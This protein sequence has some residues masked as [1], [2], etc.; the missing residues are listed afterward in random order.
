MT[1]QS[2]YGTSTQVITDEQW[3]I[4]YR[5]SQHCGITIMGGIILGSHGWGYVHLR[6][7]DSRDLRVQTYLTGS[8]RKKL[9]PDGLDKMAVNER[10]A[11]AVRF[12][13]GGNHHVLAVVS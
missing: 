5:W 8:M 4:G 3:L 10:A 9:S 12:L 11:E 1:G 6:H 2:G 13:H 7:V